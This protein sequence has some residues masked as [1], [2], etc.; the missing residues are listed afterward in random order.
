MDREWELKRVGDE[1]GKWK[2][3]CH[4]DYFDGEVWEGLV[5]R[6]GLEGLGIREKETLGARLGDLIERKLI[7]DLYIPH[8]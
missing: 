7:P 2:W 4:G 6:F 3:G 5:K 8:C 1:L